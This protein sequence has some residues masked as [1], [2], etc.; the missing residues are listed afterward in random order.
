M[1]E[2]IE[3]GTPFTIDAR[4]A[5]VVRNDG[6]ALVKIIAPG[7]GSSGYY[8][9]DVL[10][11]DVPDAFPVGTQMFWNHD[12]PTE[13]YERPEGDLS[14]LASVIVST[15]RFATVPDGPG[16]Y[17]DALVVDSFR[18]AVEQLAEWIGVS[19]RASGD[20]VD[21]EA[22]GREGAIVQRIAP[23]TERPMNR[24][25]Y[26]TKPGAGGRVVQ[27]FESAGAP[28][29][30][31]LEEPAMPTELELAESRLNDARDELVEVRAELT[32]ARTE[33]ASQHDEIERLAE[34]LRVTTRQLVDATAR[35]MVTNA[36]D[37]LPTP[38]PDVVESRVRRQL[39]DA[40]NVADDGFD[41]DAYASTVETTIAEAVAEVEAITTGNGRVDGQGDTG[42]DIDEATARERM[43]AALK[44]LNEA[45]A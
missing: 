12:T 32:E 10:E 3:V 36:I 7:W 14:R 8:S 5:R 44:S 40:V 41:A 23:A 13:E 45:T 1:P 33:I 17:A 31:N 15:P 24:V 20:V 38:L 26:V 9:R 4:E 43:A 19:I 11:R 2:L 28:P 27:L 34:S 18:P 30:P 39:A 25:D 37:A 42:R 22:E 29:A 6:T 35:D 21:G 16:M